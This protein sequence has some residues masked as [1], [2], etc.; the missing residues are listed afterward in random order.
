MV[1]FVQQGASFLG[2][3]QW[4]I[5]RYAGL[6]L[7]AMS[8][9]ATGSSFRDMI[10]PGDTLMFGGLF[11]LDGQFRI[12]C[13]KIYLLHLFGFI[14]RH[15]TNVKNWL[16]NLP[17]G[18]LDDLLVGHENKF[19]REWLT[20][21]LPGDSYWKSGDNSDAVTH[22]KAPNHVITGWHD[23]FLPQTISDY[24]KMQSEGKN[25][26]LTIGPWTHVEAAQS[27]LKDAL[28][29]LRAKMFKQDE[30]LRK[31]PVRIS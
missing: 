19:W 1:S 28:I 29:W 31:S 15:I 22:T 2:Y 16:C 26:Y 21:Y 3:S 27:G 14:N 20:Y 17:L 4:P 13:I 12:T 6:S 5:A 8:T 18:D 23:F 30:K 11:V 25:P 10:Y 7:R 24:L 9:E